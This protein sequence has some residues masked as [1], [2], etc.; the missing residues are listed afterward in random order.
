MFAVSVPNIGSLPANFRTLQLVSER[1]GDPI[2]LVSQASKGELRLSSVQVVEVI[3][4]GLV[5]AGETD[6]AGARD[7][8]VAAGVVG[9]TAHAVDLLVAL[10]SG[11]TETKAAPVTDDATKKA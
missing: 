3:L 11:A 7:R 6:E 9:M 10:V 1:V 5:S 8:V 2:A 4:C